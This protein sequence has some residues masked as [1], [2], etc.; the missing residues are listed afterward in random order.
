MI[1]LVLCVVCLKDVMGVGPTFEL[2]A[3][4]YCTE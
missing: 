1:I 4:S 2:R 3:E